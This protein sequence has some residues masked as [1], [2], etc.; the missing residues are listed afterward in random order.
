MTLCDGQ[1]QHNQVDSQMLELSEWGA[2][3]D[4]DVGPA[5]RGPYLHICP[6]GE[7]RSMRL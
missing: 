6:G 4:C 2:P 7:E 1:L 5:P 3:R